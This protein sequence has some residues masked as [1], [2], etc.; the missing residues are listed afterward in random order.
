L[1]KISRLA[2]QTVRE[3]YD[4]NY[5]RLIHGGARLLKI[6][7]PEFPTEFEAELMRLIKE[8]GE[9]NLEFVLAVLRNYE[10][11]PFIHPIAKEIARSIS[12]DSSLRGDLALALESAGIVSG[13]F[14][15]AEA[16][17]RKKS[18]VADWLNDE[19]KNVREFAKQYMADLQAMSDAERKRAQEQIELRKFQYGKR[20]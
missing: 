10:G 5:G 1:S 8:G 13:E 15:M 16:Y 20:E 18:E 9:A 3:Q 7:F 12:K 2:V 6:I 11:Q 4:G 19:N 17:E 14:G